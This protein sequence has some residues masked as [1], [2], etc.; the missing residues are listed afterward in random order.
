MVLKKQG[1]NNKNNQIIRQKP[2]KTQFEG[3]NR[4]K[5]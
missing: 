3:K 1:K 5:K 2:H 4:R